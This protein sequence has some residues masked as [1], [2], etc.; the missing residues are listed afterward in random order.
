M[1]LATQRRLAA[2][3]LKCSPHRVR[4]DPER[5][6][7][8]KEA[9]TKADLRGLI[10][11][12]AVAERPVAGISR[13][14]ARKFARKKQRGQ[15]RGQGSRKGRRGA[16][17]NKKEAWI[18]KIRSQRRLIRGLLAESRIDQ[19]T[20]RSLYTKAKGGFFRNVRNIRLYLDERGLMKK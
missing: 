14:R 10:G 4:F 15:R 3:L 18:A 19:Q 16:R 20:Y 2:Q 8:I 12:G 7:D 17:L 11:E 5:L 6:G 9:I 1:S 13:A